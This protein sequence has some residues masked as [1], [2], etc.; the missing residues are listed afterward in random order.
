MDNIVGYYFILILLTW[1]VAFVG[2]FGRN[3]WISIIGGMA[4]MIFGIYAITQG[5]AG[6]NDWVTNA[7]SIFSIAL[8]AFFSLFP[9]IEWISNL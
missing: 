5:I 1:G 2:F 9:L 4:M 8:G 3:I 7:I 6:Y